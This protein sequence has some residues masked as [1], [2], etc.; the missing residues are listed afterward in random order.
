MDFEKQQSFTGGASLGRDARPALQYG[1]PRLFTNGHNGA[2]DSQIKVFMTT[3]L[4][5]VL[6]FQSSINLVSLGQYMRG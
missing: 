4:G 5:F 2:A 6:M 1:L 3:K